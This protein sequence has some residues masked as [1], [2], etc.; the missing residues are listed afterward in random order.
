MNPDAVL[1][2]LP[3]NKEEAKSLKEIAYAMGL[4]T[5]SHTDWIRTQRTLARV[6]RTLIKWGWVD[7]DQRQSDNGKKFWHNTYWKTE[8]ASRV[9]DSELTAT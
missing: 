1:A 3:N 7:R 6:L 5:S 4:D 2:V 8:L 9:E